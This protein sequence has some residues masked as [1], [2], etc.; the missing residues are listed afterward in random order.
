MISPRQSYLFRLIKAILIIS[1]VFSFAYSEKPIFFK[2]SSTVYGN[3]RVLP[4]E[5]IKVKLGLNKKIKFKPDTLY[6]IDS[7]LIDGENKGNIIEFTFNSI[8]EDHIVE[9]WFSK[10]SKP[11][12]TIV[13]TKEHTIIV[14]TALDTNLVINEN[15]DT[16]KAWKIAQ[17][18]KELIITKIDSLSGLLIFNSHF[19]TLITVDTIIID[20]Q[21]DTS[22]YIP[23]LYVEEKQ[24]HKKGIDT[25]ASVDKYVNWD[26][27]TIIT[28]TFDL[29]VYDT[30][31]T[32]IDSFLDDKLISQSLDTTYS[33]NSMFLSEQIDTFKFKN[34]D[35]P[36]AIDYHDNTMEEH[37]IGLTAGP[38][39]FDV[40]YGTL[41]FIYK[42]KQPILKASIAI[43]NKL[44]D[45]IDQLSVYK[46]LGEN[47][48]VF[49]WDGMHKNGT[50]INCSSI[51][52]II[53]IHL[54]DGSKEK[55]KTII[56]IKR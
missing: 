33:Y 38:N 19:D 26:Y 27:D 50:I 22:I 31:I 47:S 24:I 45:M 32:I 11:D 18:I 36:T 6:I 12:T 25:V 49:K 5:D 40:N 39:P 53:N 34:P 28:T 56:G 23:K 48:I 2:I 30:V 15:L 42:A 51:I 43:Y 44:G 8:I 46:L 1:L 21:S 10:R 4:G 37:K 41:K 7:V 9:V 3:G 55:I 17:I 54:Q 29:F 13:L 52:G 35:D 16:I 20:S 14:D